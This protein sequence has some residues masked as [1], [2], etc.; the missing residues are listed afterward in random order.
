MKKRRNTT[1][2]RRNMKP[3]TAPQPQ[4]PQT[5]APPQKLD[6]IDQLNKRLDNLTSGI[7]GA[8]IRIEML[9]QKFQGGP[10]PGAEGTVGGLAAQTSTMTNVARM[11][12]ALAA[13]HKTI[14]QM[15][16]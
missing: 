5:V 14:D 4:P 16:N 15:T 7:Y 6:A 11:E 10:P 3:W 1:A 13:L 8:T 12:D 9:I 2:S